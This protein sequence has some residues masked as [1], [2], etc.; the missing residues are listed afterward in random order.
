M[1][2]FE[3]AWHHRCRHMSRGVPRGLVEHLD[4]ASPATKGF[5]A[6]TVCYVVKPPVVGGVHHKVEFLQ[7]TVTRLI[8]LI[9]VR[10]FTHVRLVENGEG[11]SDSLW[12]TIVSNAL[13]VLLSIVTTNLPVVINMRRK[14]SDVRQTLGT[15]RGQSETPIATEQTP[16]KLDE[17]FCTGHEEPGE[18]TR[19]SLS[20]SKAVGP[21]AT[22]E[23]TMPLPLLHQEPF[24][25]LAQQLQMPPPSPPPQSPLPPLPPPPPPSPSPQSLQHSLKS[26]QSTSTVAGQWDGHST[27]SAYGLIGPE[28]AWSSLGGA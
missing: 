25:R 8:P 20:L 5:K 15:E 13:L 21:T 9:G 26:R 2:D 4:L 14:P 17:E 7:L 19:S 10:Y 12:S 24:V 22:P 1:T 11:G 23:Q 27:H 18:R 3:M 6:G 28:R 16:P